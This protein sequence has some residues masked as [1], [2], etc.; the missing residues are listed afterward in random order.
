MRVIS[1]RRAVARQRP[2]ACL[3]VLTQ[4]PLFHVKRCRARSPAAAVSRQYR[5]YPLFAGNDRADVGLNRFG[6][7]SGSMADRHSAGAA[8]PRKPAIRCLM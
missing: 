7:D 8:T 6:V 5:E 3:A 1:A 4:R 2:N